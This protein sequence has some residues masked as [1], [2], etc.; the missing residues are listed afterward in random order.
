MNFFHRNQLYL[1]FF[2]SFIM[3]IT[4]CTV[5]DI[6]SNDFVVMMTIMIL[7]LLII[8][9]VIK[10]SVS[11]FVCALGPSVLLGRQGRSA[12]ANTL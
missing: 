6:D 1:S 12:K 4:R 8:I 5:F 3:N 11:P 2:H 7:F 10:V 9:I